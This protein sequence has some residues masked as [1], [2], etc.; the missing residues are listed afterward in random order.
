ML[1]SYCDGKSGWPGG[2]IS[3]G[4]ADVT[5]AESCDSVNLSTDALNQ[6]LAAADSGDASGVTIDNLN[7]IIGIV[8]VNADNLNAYQTAISLLTSGTSIDQIN[9]LQSLI[10]L[11]LIHI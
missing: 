6:L 4:S 11:S 7:S 8:N 3:V 10:N 1:V 2:P 5:P 9:E